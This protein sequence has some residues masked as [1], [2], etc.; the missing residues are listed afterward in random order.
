MVSSTR[1]VKEAVFIYVIIFSITFV[2][3]P[4]FLWADQQDDEIEQLYDRFGEK[5]ESRVKKHSKSKKVQ[6]KKHSVQESVTV[7]DLVE[8]APFEDI[9]VIQRR[10][11]PKTSR[12]EFSSEALVTTNNAFFTNIGLNATISYYFQEPYG[13]E[14]KYRWMTSSSKAI[15]KNLEA[16][17]QVDTKAFVEP[18]S[19]FGISFKWSPIY[20]KIAWFD[21]SIIPFDIYFT[22]GF[23]MTQTA[24]GKNEMT[25]NIGMGQL[26]ALSKSVAVRWDFNW[27]IYQA[28][29]QNES[30]GATQEEKKL[31][32]DLMLSL[33]MSYFIPEA[34]YR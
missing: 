22:P 16:N 1:R 21:E 9:A 18:R 20:G 2:S 14:L 7:S 32:S 8:L 6:R 23:G 13:V 19:F 11:L 27:S 3:L 30:T 28:T 26:F 4:R 12:F 10:F 17:Q 5:E 31:H 29:V 34:S 33:G 15:T 25:F 24:L